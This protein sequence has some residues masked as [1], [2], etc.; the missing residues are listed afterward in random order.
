MLT[1]LKPVRA[2][3]RVIL[4]ISFFVLFVALWGAISY[5]GLVA[6]HFL[7]NPVATVS[8]GIIVTSGAAK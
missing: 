1:P 7:A 2:G 6:P 5:G 8:A 3:A 4:G